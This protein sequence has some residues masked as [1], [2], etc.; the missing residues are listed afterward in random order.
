MKTKESRC[1]IRLKPAAVEA[2]KRYR[3]R[4]A[5][6]QLETGGLYQDQG[7]VLAGRV[8]DPINPSQPSAEVLCQAARGLSFN[9]LRHTCASLLFQKNVYPGFVQVLL[10]HASVTITLDTYSYMLPGMSN[11]AADAMGEALG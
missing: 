2:V 1:T 8:W 5:E 4:Q 9:D 7:L 6:E 3:A 10:G 11:E